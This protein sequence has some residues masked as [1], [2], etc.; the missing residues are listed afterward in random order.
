MDK[1]VARTIIEQLKTDTAMA[2]DN[3]TQAKIQ[4][5]AQP[6]RSWLDD[7]PFEVGEQVL[8]VYEG[9]LSSVQKKG[10]VLVG[11]V[12]ASV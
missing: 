4:Q 5:A 6:N 3:L 12:Y 8:C 10:K 11:K 9:Q 7:F 1:T 2:R